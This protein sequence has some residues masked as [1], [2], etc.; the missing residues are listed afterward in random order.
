V[1]VAA[2]PAHATDYFSLDLRHAE[3][4][5]EPLGPAAQFVPPPTSAPLPVATIRE[6]ASTQAVAATS[7]RVR[8]TRVREAARK[9][10]R[11]PLNAFASYSGP[12][13][14][15]CAGANVCVFDGV[16]GRWHAR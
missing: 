3:F 12:R 13:N 1:L 10:H 5:A 4:S 7:R 15:S 11:N 16:H 2:A 14:R 9:S 6:P 8:V